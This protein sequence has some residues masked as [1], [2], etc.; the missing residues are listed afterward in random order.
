MAGQSNRHWS[1]IPD[2]TISD[3][4]QML[5]HPDYTMMEIA[6]LFGLSVPELDEIISDQ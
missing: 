4:R 2:K 3:I 1:E 5:L 6:V